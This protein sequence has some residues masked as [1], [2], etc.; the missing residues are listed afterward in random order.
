MKYKIGITEAGDAGIDLSWVD[1]LNFVDG[2][3]V[4]TKQITPQFKEAVLKN[5]NK[6]IIHATITGYGATMLEPNVP[7]PQ[8]EYDRLV[9]L[10]NDGFPINKIVVRVDPIIPT[11]KGVKLAS[12]IIK[13]GIGLGFIN[14]RISVIDMYPHVRQR[15]SQNNLPLPY[16]ESGFYPSKAQFSDV[17]EMLKGLMEYGKSKIGDDFTIE[18]CAEP[19]LKNVIHE[20]CIAARDL[21]LLDLCDEKSEFYGY[22]RKDCMCYSGKTELLS[23]KK[24]C[25]H[26]CLYCYW[27]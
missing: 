8:N 25:P 18:A 11:T 9:E 17:D 5:K 13:A 10:I 27:K 26:G 20:G 23:S 14:Y 15:F 12:Q 6:L 1:K 24:R 22:Q 21:E 19:Q 4:I 3:I 2:A 16:G 7:A